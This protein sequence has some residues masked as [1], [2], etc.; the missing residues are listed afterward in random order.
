MDNAKVQRGKFI[1]GI[2]TFHEKK[3][4][5]GT[6]KNEKYNRRYAGFFQWVINKTKEKNQ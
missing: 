4:L 3:K 6:V 5:N 1:E 2:S